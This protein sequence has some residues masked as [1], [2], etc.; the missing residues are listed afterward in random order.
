M[1]AR[2]RYPAHV[3]QLKASLEGTRKA[4]R[5]HRK[6]CAA[7]TRAHAALRPDLGCDIG[8]DWAKDES[9]FTRALERVGH[10]ELVMAG[11]QLALW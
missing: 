2:V 4:M 9:R 3:R 6:S 5:S 7:C 8:W 11:D 1:V 10:P